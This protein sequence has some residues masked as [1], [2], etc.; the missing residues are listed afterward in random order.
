MEKQD[1]TKGIGKFFNY[2]IIS[3]P[4]P[5]SGGEVEE[6]EQQTGAYTVRRGRT[7]DLRVVSASRILCPCSWSLLTLKAIQT[8][9]I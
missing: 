1:G 2:I 4:H 8:F 3:D 5:V 6:K 7:E 9:L